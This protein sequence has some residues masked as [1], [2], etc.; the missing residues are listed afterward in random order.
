[1]QRLRSLRDRSTVTRA[2]FAGPAC[3]MRVQQLGGCFVV[4]LE[5][6]IDIFSVSRVQERLC[7][8]ADLDYVVVD[9][10]PARFDTAL[11]RALRVA[12][13][14]ARLHG[15]VMCV[16]GPRDV[17]EGLLEQ[18]EADGDLEYY[19]DVADAVESALAA[20]K[21]HGQATPDNRPA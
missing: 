21:R 2:A 5:G 10:N 9:S 8:L 15:R 18:A 13:Q 17:V 14:R 20:R 16:A 6:E 12:G 19:P 11:A 1:M 3:E 4:R 7:G